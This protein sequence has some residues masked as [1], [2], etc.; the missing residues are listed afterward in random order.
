MNTAIKTLHDALNYQLQGLL[1]AERKI[2]EE[3]N[4][5]ST[6]LHSDEVKTALQKYIDNADNVQL[7]LERVFSYLMLEPVARKNEVINKMIEE[8]QHQLTYASSVNLKDVMM[9]GCIKNINAYKTASFQTCYLMAA[10]LELETAADLMQEIL[11]WELATGKQLSE[12]FI[13]EFNRLY[14]PA[15]AR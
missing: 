6:H 13:H 1:Y 4:R 5:C 7:K 15:K 12:L 3:F 9:I 11:E 10:E 2:R 8:T 14:N